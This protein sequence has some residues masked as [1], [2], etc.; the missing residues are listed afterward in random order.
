MP[1]WRGEGCIWSLLYVSLLTDFHSACLPIS[2]R[3]LVNATGLSINQVITPLSFNSPYPLYTPMRALIKSFDS[4]L[5][6]HSLTHFVSAYLVIHNPYYYLY[7]ILILLL[8][9]IHPIL[10]SCCRYSSPYPILSLKGISDC[11]IKFKRPLAHSPLELEAQTSTRP[12]AQPHFFI[13]HYTNKQPKKCRI[14]SRWRGIG[15]QACISIHTY[16]IMGTHIT[17]RKISTHRHLLRGVKGMEV[18]RGLQKRISSATFV[19]SH[20]PER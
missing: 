3:C 15:T 14:L 17:S 12:H 18:P 8:I 10:Y 5:K 16:Q 11:I 19:Q 6:P 20:S 2:R 7:T 4:V 9:Y 1:I 13:I